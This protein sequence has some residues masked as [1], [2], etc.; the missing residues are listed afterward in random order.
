VTNV[1]PSCVAYRE[2]LLTVKELGNNGGGATYGLRTKYAF[3]RECPRIPTGKEGVGVRWW[4]VFVLKGMVGNID[5]SF[6]LCLCVVVVLLFVVFCVVC[7]CYLL[8]D[9]CLL[10]QGTNRKAR[11]MTF[12]NI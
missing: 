12:I 9:C 6:F 7:C 11:T 8:F 2:G 3:V 5:D 4:C 1:Q 10:V